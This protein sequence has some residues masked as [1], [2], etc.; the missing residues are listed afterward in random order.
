MIIKPFSVIKHYQ[1]SQY[2][3]TVCNPRSLQSPSQMTDNSLEDILMDPLI[4]MGRMP[5]ETCDISF[6]AWMLSQVVC[7]LSSPPPTPP[8]HPFGELLKMLCR[9][10]PYCR[11][12]AN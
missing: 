6:P 2:R 4:L 12:D 7:F 9:K 10:I 5:F 1:C 3:H 8:P 11:E